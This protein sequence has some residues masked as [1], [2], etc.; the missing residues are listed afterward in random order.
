METKETSGRRFPTEKQEVKL[1][2]RMFLVNLR[3]DN[4]DAALQ[5]A[6][7]RPLPSASS[8]DLGFDH[9]VL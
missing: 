2:T 8:Q 1:L 9:Q 4:P 3:V 5:A 7:K 6:L